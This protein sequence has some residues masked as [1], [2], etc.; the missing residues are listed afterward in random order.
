MRAGGSDLLIPA[1]EQACEELTD[2]ARNRAVAWAAVVY[3][4]AGDDGRLPLDPL[5]LRVVYVTE[6]PQTIR[7]A[8]TGVRQIVEEADAT[9]VDR[10]CGSEIEI[11]YADQVQTLVCRCVPLTAESRHTWIRATM[12]MACLLVQDAVRATEQAIA[13]GTIEDQVVFDDP[14]DD[15]DDEQPA[16]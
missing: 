1:I 12:E 7:D 3:D 11:A 16:P 10:D 6:W 2:Q 8:T 4:A 9:Y 14:G 15:V 5:A 13:D